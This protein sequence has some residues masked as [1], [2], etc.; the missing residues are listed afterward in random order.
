M[1]SFALLSLAVLTTFS[2]FKPSKYVNNNDQHYL[3][4]F[5][6]D[7]NYSEDYLLLPAWVPKRIDYKP[8]SLIEKGYGGYAVANRYFFPGWN[9]SVNG[10]VVN[11]GGEVD[12]GRI[13]FE[14]SPD[15]DN[16]KIYWSET[17]L[18]KIFDVISLFGFSVA[19]WLIFKKSKAYG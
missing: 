3:D 9:V 10:K 11:R 6:K 7:K 4:R 12:T 17:T 16:I 15:S 19:M 14:A 5:F 18:R 13:S 2:Y 1:V 8:N